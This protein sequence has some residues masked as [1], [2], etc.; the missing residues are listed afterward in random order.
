MLIDGRTYKT[1]D[2][3]DINSLISFEDWL[4]R[5]LTIYPDDASISKEHLV[6]FLEYI[7]GAVYAQKVKE[8]KEWLKQIEFLIERASNES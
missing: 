8:K 1:F 3:K 2:L 4:K 5:N 6:Y 7:R